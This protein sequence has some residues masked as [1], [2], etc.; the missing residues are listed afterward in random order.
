MAAR[1][2]F[3]VLTGVHDGA[4]APIVN[5]VTLVGS[6]GD[7]DVVL[8]DPGIAAMHASLTLGGDAWFVRLHAAPSAASP[9]GVRHEAAEARQTDV[10]TDWYVPFRVGPAWVS[11]VPAEFDWGSSLDWAAPQADAQAVADELPPKAVPVFRRAGAGRVALVVMLLLL[12]VGELLVLTPSVGKLAPGERAAVPGLSAAEHERQAATTRLTQI[13][14]AA[15]LADVTVKA[16]ADRIA[17]VGFVDTDEQLVRLNDEVKA[18]AAPGLLMQVKAGSELARRAQQFL[19]DP[20]IDVAYEGGGRVR[21]AGR[22]VRMKAGASLQSRLAQLRADLGSSI[23]V[24]DEIEHGADAETAKALEHRMPIRIAEV[25]A[26]EPAHFRTVDGARYFEG[27]RL[28]DGAE[29][30]HIGAREILFRKGGHDIS[31]AVVE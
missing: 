30:V 9:D 18:V 8:T 6:G 22:P 7:C 5:A 11:V 12:V 14:T 10:Q 13:V 20:G 28:P 3:V 1:A 17:M 15:K 29:V 23:N 16:G 4:S 26:D 27:A 25:Q 19:A 2:K 31:Y 21:L 24:K